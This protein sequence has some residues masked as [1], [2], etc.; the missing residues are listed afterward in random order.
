MHLSIPGKVMILNE[1]WYILYPMEDSRIWNCMVSINLCL[2]K[3]S[4]CGK[5][6]NRGGILHNFICCVDGNVFNQQ[7]WSSWSVLTRTPGCCPGY[8]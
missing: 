3:I 4:H 7:V 5:W 1:I 2:M 6:E 8:S